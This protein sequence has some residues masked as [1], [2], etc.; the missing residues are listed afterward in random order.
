MSVQEEFSAVADW[1]ARAQRPPVRA[2]REWAVVGVALLPLGP[3]FEAVR[4]P[5]RLVAAALRTAHP[6]EIAGRL[7]PLLGGPVIFDGRTLDG[8]YYPLMRPR[9]ERRWEYE[10]FAPC[11][12]AG[13]YLGVPRVERR[14]PPGT[15]WV[16]PPR[17]EGDLCEPAAVAAL[18]AHAVSAGGEGEQA[19]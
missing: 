2:R 6:R 15:Y 4:L 1:L 12:G 11:L 13:T 17:F 19:Q 7:G 18:V 3:R 10:A 16:A 8:T 5:G 9:A 14:K